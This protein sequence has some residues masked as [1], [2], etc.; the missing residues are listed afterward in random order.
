MRF[1]C[2]KQ[3]IEEEDFV[4][5]FSPRNQSLTELEVQENLSMLILCN[6]AQDL[7]WL[8]LWV[9]AGYFRTSFEHLHFHLTSECRLSQTNLSFACTR[10]QVWFGPSHWGFSIRAHCREKHISQAPVQKTPENTLAKYQHQTLLPFSG[11]WDFESKNRSAFIL[12]I[13]HLNIKLYF[14]Q[15]PNNTCIPKRA[16]QCR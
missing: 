6:A 12:D 15:V 1:I 9:S 14:E 11:I 2:N 8:L 3:K 7:L 5:G 4:I 10:K 16:I 13:C